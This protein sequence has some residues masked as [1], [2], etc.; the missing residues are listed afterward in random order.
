M[1]GGTKKLQDIWKII[2][3]LVVKSILSIITLHVNGLNFPRYID[4]LND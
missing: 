1:K 4:L 3:K 2:N